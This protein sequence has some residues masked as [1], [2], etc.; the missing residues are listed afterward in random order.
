M[1]T[2]GS[3]LHYCFGFN[4]TQYALGPNSLIINQPITLDTGSPYTVTMVVGAEGTYSNYPEQIYSE[5][6]YTSVVADPT[7][8]V[9]ASNASDYTISYSDGIVP[10]VSSVPEPASALLLAAGFALLSRCR[11][12]A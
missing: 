3:N 12:D 6:I 10:Q 7:F 8:Q 4:C 11:K 5:P 1:T 9:L 2:A